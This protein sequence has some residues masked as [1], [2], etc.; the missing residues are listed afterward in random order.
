MDCQIFEDRESKVRSYC[1]KYPVVFSKALN[2]EL[3]SEFCYRTQNA[4]L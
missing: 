1:R 2:S 4:R 3:F